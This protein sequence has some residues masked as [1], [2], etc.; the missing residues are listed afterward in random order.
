MCGGTNPTD[1]NNVKGTGACFKEAGLD[2]EHVLGFSSGEG[3]MRD[4][5]IYFNYVGE[6]CDKDEK[7]N[8][9]LE[10]IAE[11]DYHN[12]LDPISLIKVGDATAIRVNLFIPTESHVIPFHPPPFH[13]ARLMRLYAALQVR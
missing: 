11:C 1:C 2:K 3:V 9:T 5:I 10:I 12:E 7:K 4:G 13:A 6:K 8:Y